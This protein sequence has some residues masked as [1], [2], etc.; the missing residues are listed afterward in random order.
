[1]LSNSVKHVQREG[2]GKVEPP[3]IFI[4]KGKQVEG[5]KEKRIIIRQQDTHLCLLIFWVTFEGE[6][7]CQLIFVNTA[8]HLICSINDLQ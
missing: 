8:N 5:N 1:M 6:S 7:F 2:L 3:I 4:Q